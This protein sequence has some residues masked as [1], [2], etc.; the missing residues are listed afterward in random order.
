MKDHATFLNAAKVVIAQRPDVHFVAAGRGVDVAPA[1]AGAVD[2]LDLHGRVHLLP[3]RSD[4]PRFLAALDVAVSSSY[5][6]AFPNV[7]AEAMAC[8]TP[9]VA[10]DVG[11]SAR[12]VGEAGVIVPPGDPASLAAGIAYV[13]DLDDAAYATFGRMARERI[14]SMFSLEAAAAQYAELY[15]QLSGRHTTARPD[16][17]LCAG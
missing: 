17:S 6:E 5:G 15:L 3:E 16:R 11:D 12:I 4:A 2:R 8:G 9:C 14:V 13:L 7:V 1:I 10:T